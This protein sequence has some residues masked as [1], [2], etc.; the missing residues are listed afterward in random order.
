VQVIVNLVENAVDAMLDA[1]TENPMVTLGAQRLENGRIQV[2]VADNGPGIPK[3]I[4]DKIFDP[5]YTTKDVG[6]GLGMG[7]SI[8]HTIVS[9]HSGV[10]AIESSDERGTVFTF[11]LVDALARP[12]DI[13]T[14][15]DQVSGELH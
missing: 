10:L 1:G 13:E 9:N 3:E 12:K 14:N 7:L 6:A 8:C 4:Q 5:F 2:R 11:D 15:F